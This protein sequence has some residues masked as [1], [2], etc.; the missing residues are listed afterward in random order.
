MSENT[1]DNNLNQS[2]GFSSL[3]GFLMSIIGF[4]V[5]VGSMWR[6]PYVCGT[7]GGA[8]FI[9][10][11]I[12]VILIIGIPLLTGEI[13]MGYVTQKTT[14]GAYKELKPGSKWYCAG[15]LHSIV[16]LSV[17]G[18]TVPIYVWVLAYIYR[19]ATGFFK[20][21]DPAGIANSFTALTGDYKTM[22]IFAIINW[23]VTAIV[24]SGSVS[25]GI[26]KVN[27][28]LLPALG[29]IMVVCIVIG[30]RV[31]GAFKGVAYMFKPNPSTFSLSTVST[32]IGQAFFAIGIGMLASMI[33]GS[34]IKKKNENILKQA[35]IVGTS[36]LG[37]GIA[38]GLM[39]FPMVFAFGLQPSAGVGLTMITLPNV[40]NYIAGGRFIGTLFY[41]GFFF[42]AL[43]SSIGLGEAITA[44]VKDGFNL[45][46]KKA[47]AVVMACSVIIGSCSILI[48]GFLDKADIITSN[49]L[50]VISG[51]LIA[52][53]VGWVWGADNF[54]DA[55]NIQ[56]KWT[57]IW[58]KVSIKFVCPIA[59]IVIFLGNFI[60]M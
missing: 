50:L 11:Y 43:S 38:S 9:F 26:E 13:S 57:R 12:G 7:N 58:L 39:I 40:F 28:F 10:T 4:A 20:G 18:Y 37:A 36:I 41:V 51:L 49:Y 48:P 34:Y 33:F 2:E 23:V 56:K 30:L 19:T 17:F 22:F 54:L 60:K 45:T 3:F 6:F 21:L 46:R 15:Y 24:I 32:A 1:N 44:V 42:A 55:V 8:L 27:K 35:T 25:N 47:V 59:I 53:F 52:I 5:G 14:I 29:V 16:A 31:P